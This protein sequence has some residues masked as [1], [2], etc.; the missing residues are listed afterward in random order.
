MDLFYADS[1][2]ASKT[3]HILVPF[4]GVSGITSTEKVSHILSD[5]GEV[6]SFSK[7]SVPGSLNFPSKVIKISCGRDHSALVTE[8]FELFTWGNGKSGA[9]GLGS[10]NSFTNPQ[11]VLFSNDT[12]IINVSCGAWHTIILPKSQTQNSFILVTGRNSEGQLG[13]GNT[14]KELIPLKVQFPEEVL[15]IF[16]GT[17]HS[18]VLGQSRNIYS[19]GDNSFGQLGLGHKRSSMR[20][21]RVL[22]ENVESVA[23]GRHS[24]AIVKGKVFVWGT[25]AF[26]ELNLPTLLPGPLSAIQVFVG[27]GIGCAI[28]A[29]SQL[30]LWGGKNMEKKAF[31]AEITVSCISLNSGIHIFIS[32]DPSLQRPSSISD[33]MHISYSGYNTP[34]G[35]ITSPSRGSLQPKFTFDNI[36]DRN[37][38]KYLTERK[39]K[40]ICTL[41]LDSPSYEC[42]NMK[43]KESD[44][45]VND[46]KNHHV[47]K[48]EIDL[49]GD[50]KEF[51]EKFFDEKNVDSDLQEELKNIIRNTQF[52][53]EENKKLRENVVKVTQEKDKL[54]KSF[55][56]EYEIKKFYEEFIEDMEIEKKSMHEKMT[57]EI[58]QLK[59]ENEKIQCLL[60]STRQ[61][62]NELCE[63]LLLIQKKSSDFQLQLDNYK[64]IIIELESKIKIYKDEA[65]ILASNT[66]KS[67]VFNKKKALE[68]KNEEN[69]DIKI[70][71]NKANKDCIENEDLNNEGSTANYGFEYFS[72]KED[73]IREADFPKLTINDLDDEYQDE[74][75]LLSPRGNLTIRTQKRAYEDIRNKVKILK[76][77]RSTAQPRMQ[78]F[79]NKLNK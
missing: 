69:F 5:T 45:I 44:D 61:E 33:D 68:A 42:D 26:G 30:W 78:E 13:T 40:I 46:R 35:F 28:D 71:N 25:A 7:T 70:Y 57:E 9:L 41:G 67:G 53:Y 43:N 37:I 32:S 39:K 22:L 74:P 27:D 54:L 63:K 60:G 76:K 3:F 62:N 66:L 29:D 20:F 55:K 36:T 18:I 51:K 50:L 12:P 47:D 48:T 59:L 8:N 15:D 1:F 56:S 77:N 75:L 4:T 49:L 38:D 24:A 64:N 17:N 31:K 21:L 65:E 11:K 73:K 79:E 16:C 52:L 34:K 72:N 6:Y 58:S 19:T 23:C 2:F 10:T 14:C